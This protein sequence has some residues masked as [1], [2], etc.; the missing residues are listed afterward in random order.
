MNDTL[1]Q[2]NVVNFVK[3]INTEKRNDIIFLWKKSK[4]ASRVLKATII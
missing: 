4:N 1:S 3:R 2:I